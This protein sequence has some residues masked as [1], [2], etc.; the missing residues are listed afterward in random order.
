MDQW[1]NIQKAI[2]MVIS[3]VGLCSVLVELLAWRITVIWSKLHTLWPLFLRSSLVTPGLYLK[4]SLSLSQNAYIFF[5][6]G[7]VRGW[8]FLLFC[9][10]HLWAIMVEQTKTQMINKTYLQVF[11]GLKI[12]WR[13]PPFRVETVR[14]VYFISL[15]VSYISF[16]TGGV[17]FFKLVT[18]SISAL[19]TNDTLLQW[20]MLMLLMI[21]TSQ[22]H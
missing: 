8:V 14:N 20:V 16:K 15:Y 1:H 22:T 11:Q 17:F 4:T 19:C 2:K 12:S 18:G 5:D 9:L 10:T 13:L 21:S 7:W 6:W 3:F